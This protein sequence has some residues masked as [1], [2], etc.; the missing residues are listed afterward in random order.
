M[1]CESHGHSLVAPLLYF[2][3]FCFF[4]FTTGDSVRGSSE[5]AGFILKNQQFLSYC[6]EIIYLS[7][8]W[9]SF[10]NPSMKS[11]YRGLSLQFFIYLQ[12]APL[13]IYFVFAVFRVS[14]WSPQSL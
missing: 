6:R 14:A 8:P 7:Q 3:I 11:Y 12:K 5:Y 2:F 13:Y 4:M 9:L 10:L 1:T